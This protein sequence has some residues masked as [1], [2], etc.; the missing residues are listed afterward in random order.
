MYIDMVWPGHG[1]ACD[2]SDCR[3]AG[4]FSG[5]HHTRMDLQRNEWVFLRLTKSKSKS[6]LTFSA[7]LTHMLRQSRCIL[8][9]TATFWTQMRIKS[10]A[11]IVYSHM[12]SV[13]RKSKRKIL[14]SWTSDKWSL[15]H[16]RWFFVL[17]RRSQ[18]SQ[19][20]SRTFEWTNWC[21]WKLLRFLNDLAHTSQ[22][23]FRM[24]RNCGS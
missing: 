14:W 8:I 23:N 2:R 4:M 6:K 9:S 5:T 3:V 22:T 7:V 15:T 17:N 19:M 21:W 16:L 13:I 18:I 1:F 10:T 24:R 20:K 12:I 11:A